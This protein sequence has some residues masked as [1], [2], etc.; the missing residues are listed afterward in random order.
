MKEN[1]KKV[2]EIQKKSDQFHEAESKIAEEKLFAELKD[3]QN[4]LPKTKK[5]K[6]KTF[7]EKIKNLLKIS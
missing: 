6:K 7:R 2:P 3:T 1:M 4:N 5:E